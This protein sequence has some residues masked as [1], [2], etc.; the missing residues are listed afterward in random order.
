[1]GSVISDKEE[2]INEDLFWDVF[3]SGPIL[4]ELGRHLEIR[5]IVNLSKTCKGLSGLYNEVSRLQWDIDTLLKRFLKYP[6]HFRQ[7]LGLTE[8]LITGSFALEFFE[9]PFWRAPNLDLVVQEGERAFGLLEYLTRCE[10]YVYDKEPEPDTVPHG[11]RYVDKVSHM[12]PHPHLQITHVPQTRES[13]QLRYASCGTPK[14][15]PSQ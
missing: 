1:M 15:P 2:S 10:D 12:R 9:R 3:S 8:A 14:T 5:D 11:F 4:D 13:S 7:R 6:K